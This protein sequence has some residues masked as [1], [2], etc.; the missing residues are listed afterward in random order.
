MPFMKG[1]QQK[2]LCKS[3]FFFLTEG[4]LFVFKFSSLAIRAEINRGVQKKKKSMTSRP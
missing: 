3:S 1:E 2:G 4:L